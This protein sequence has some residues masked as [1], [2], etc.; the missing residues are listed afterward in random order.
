MD[1]RGRVVI[2][3]QHRAFINENWAGEELKLTADPSGILLLMT[4]AKFDDTQKI[5]SDLPVMDK[6]ARFYRGTL[7]GMAQ[8][9]SLD[10]LG[11]IAV[12]A[13]NRQFAGLDSEVNVVGMMD[14][15]QLTR[16]DY[17]SDLGMDVASGSD[18][19]IKMPRGWEGFSV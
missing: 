13:V 9:A 3:S 16:V 2:P 11:R 14:H 8:A 10:K 6:R 7:V 15:F 4:K 18:D 5:I 12:A 1:D 17:M 19:E